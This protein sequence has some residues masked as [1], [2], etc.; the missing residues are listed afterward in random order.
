MP[1]EPLVAQLQSRVKGA[2]MAL[3]VEGFADK[4]ARWNLNHAKWF[5]FSVLCESVE[6]IS[7]SIKFA[8]EQNIPIV[9]YG[10][11]HSLSGGS[12]TE[13]GLVID[14]RR[15]NNV[16]VDPAKKLLYVQGGALW[17]DVE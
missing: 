6:D 7:T 13:T 3:G 12:S 10:G 8:N 4:L 17:S 16:R 11:G 14:L 5:R 2:V 1:A 15:M 9:I